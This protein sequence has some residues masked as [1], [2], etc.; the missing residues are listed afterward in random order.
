MKTEQ[1]EWKVDIYCTHISNSI[2][3]KKIISS[4]EANKS[5]KII[6][7]IFSSYVMYH[8]INKALNV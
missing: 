3:V 8:I 5:S 4:S 2:V 6:I 1:N 7:I